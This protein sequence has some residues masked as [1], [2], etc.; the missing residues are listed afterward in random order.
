MSSEAYH[1][2]YR[3]PSCSRSAD[4]GFASTARSTSVR[5]T[6]ASAPTDD[7]REPRSSRTSASLAAA[8]GRPGIIPA[9][10]AG[11]SDAPS[12]AGGGVA[13][14]AAAPTQRASAEHMA[15]ARPSPL[16]SCSPSGPRCS[17]WIEPGGP[18]VSAQPSA[19][20]AAP[21]RRSAA[22]RSASAGA[23]PSAE[24]RRSSRRRA[25]AASRRRRPPSP[26]RPARAARAARRGDATRDRSAAHGAPPRASPPRRAPRRLGMRRRRA[27]ERCRAA[28]SR[29]GVRGVRAA[30][31]TA[32]RGGAA[33]ATVRSS[34]VPPP[35]APAARPTRR[36]RAAH[37]VRRARPRPP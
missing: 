14:A 21:L 16:V 24:P 11:T 2:P 17:A 20:A 1:P 4:G 9:P 32:P 33:S 19:C 12:A 34:R 27:S 29:C 26:R 6:P 7:A 36:R 23:P 18:T 22:R 3:P 25:G 15:V 31:S 30:P 8:V 35:T 5:T 28:G 37:R 13:A 10:V